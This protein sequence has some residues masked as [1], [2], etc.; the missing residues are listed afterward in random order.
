[1]KE[2][3]QLPEL[4]QDFHTNVLLFES[5]LLKLESL[6]STW[7]SGKLSGRYSEETVKQAVSDLYDDVSFLGRD[8][9]N[10]ALWINNACAFSRLS[11]KLPC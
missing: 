3:R 10:L 11:G 5:A 4:L 2:Q 8:V 1:M 6:E 7:E 9:A